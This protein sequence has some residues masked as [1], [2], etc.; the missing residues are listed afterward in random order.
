MDR[1]GIAQSIMRGPFLRAFPAASS[2][3]RLNS[4]RNRSSTIRTML[5][6][7]RRYWPASASK[8]P[9]AMTSS[10]SPKARWLYEDVIV[11][12]NTPQDAA[13]SITIG[14]QLVCRCSPASASCQCSPADQPGGY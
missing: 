9:T 5:R 4:T 8:T 7:P 10:T 12:M 1:D 2:P 11:A 14:D 13:E 6:R 3:V